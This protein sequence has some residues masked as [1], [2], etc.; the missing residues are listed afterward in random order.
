MKLK[1]TKEPVTSIA[2]AIT[3]PEPLRS[4]TWCYVPR[5]VLSFVLTLLLVWAVVPLARATGT[6]ISEPNSTNYH[7]VSHYRVKIS[8]GPSTVWKHLVDLHSWMF[9][10]EMAHVSGPHHEAG[11]VLRLYAGQDFLVEITKT[12]PNKVIVIANLPS[13]FQGEHSTGVSVT[14]LNEADGGTIVDLT[15]SR[16][17]TWHGEGADPVRARRESTEFNAATDARW[18]RFLAKLCS[19]CEGT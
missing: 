9:E 4:L 6:V 2:C 7:F 13:E 8:A 3:A 5:G 11:E 12:I 16:R 15:M 18:E 14:T 19:L 17:Y 10:F 1:Q